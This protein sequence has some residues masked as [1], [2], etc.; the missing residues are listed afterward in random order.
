MDEVDIA[1]DAMLESLE[2][3]LA[4]LRKEPKGPQPE[5]CVECEEPIPPARQK[6]RLDLC[7]DCAQLRERAQRVL[8]NN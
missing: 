4:A 8:R 5:F 1:N 7:I 2:R 6:L 3:T